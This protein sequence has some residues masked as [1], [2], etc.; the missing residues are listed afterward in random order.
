MIELVNI[1]LSTYTE[2][3]SVIYN[4]T[5]ETES[6]RALQEKYDNRLWELP[7]TKLQLSKYIKW[8]S[9]NKRHAKLG[10][11]DTWLQAL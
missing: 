11:T 2:L 1:L 10:K 7:I 4:T 9:G 5:N 6:F 8:I 3:F